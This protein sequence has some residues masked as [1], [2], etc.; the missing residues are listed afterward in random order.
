MICVGIGCI[1]C[2]AKFE[3]IDIALYKFF[4]EIHLANIQV[5]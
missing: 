1:V 2:W 3:D 4:T 5:I